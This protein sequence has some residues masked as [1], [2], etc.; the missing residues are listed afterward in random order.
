MVLAAIERVEV[1]LRVKI[2]FTLGRRGAYAHLN[3]AA[4]DGQFTQ[5]RSG[6]PSI[7]REWL[8]KMLTAQN[9]SSEDFVVHF[10]NKYDGKLPVWVLTEIMDFGSMT[11]LYG[12]LK[13]V[14]R[15]EIARSLGVLTNHGSGNGPA[16][17]NW[18]RVLNYVRNVSAHHSRLWNRNLVNQIAPRHL[19]GIPPLAHLTVRGGD[20]HFRIYSTLCI[21]A[22]LLS[23]FGD[24][25]RWAA[26]VRDLLTTEIPHCGRKLQELGIPANWTDSP[27]WG[28]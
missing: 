6:R 19:S 16:L 10:K 24:Q 21:L 23:G 26:S 15:D 20:S 3:G 11:Y 27:L 9:R 22:F 28:A 13:A 2:G 7:H 8:D 4:L 18:L 1:A 17:V 12:G 5:T 25:S 14:D